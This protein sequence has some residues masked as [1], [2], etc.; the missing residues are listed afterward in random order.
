[1][2]QNI[3]IFRSDMLGDTL[4]TLPVVEALK[5][6]DPDASVTFVCHP[7][8]SD[9]LTRHPHI[10]QVVPF[11]AGRRAARASE[12]LRLWRA[13][14]QKRYDLTVVAHARKDFHVL[15]RLVGSKRSVGYRRKWGRYLLT[16]TIEDLKYQAGKH[17]IEYNLD[18]LRPLGLDP[19]SPVFRIPSA[20]DDEANARFAKASVGAE[21]GRSL[22]LVH[23]FSSDARKCW[24][25]SAFV[26]VIRALARADGEAIGILGSKEEQPS[27]EAMR[28]EAG[29]GVF[30]FCGLT[31]LRGLVALIRSARLIIG[32]DS[33]PVHL[34]AG[35][36]TPALC[37]FARFAGGPSPARWKPWGSVHHVLHEDF[38]QLT[39]E[40]VLMEAHRMIRNLA[41]E[42]PLPSGG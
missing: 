11:S 38:N 17:E 16:D 39:A 8:L 5:A 4:L 30:N 12:L 2:T 10:H 23:P 24:S 35:T 32:Q 42:P 1:M 40:R 36:G 33:G 6:Y 26:D 9:L 31:S 25:R 34:A 29:R 7:D 18:L 28:K 22:I 20:M 14:K 3:L 13:L 37:L 19:A 27:A 15:S 41:K 21:E